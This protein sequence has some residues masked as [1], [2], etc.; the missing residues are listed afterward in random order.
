MQKLL[1]TI[2]GLILLPVA[3]SAQRGSN[4]NY[5]KI[6]GVVLEA[7]G[8]EQPINFAT[9]QLLPQGTYVSTDANGN[10][11]FAKVH[12]GKV[13]IKVQF[14]GMQDIDT[15]VNVIAAKDYYFEFKMKEANFRLEEIVVSAQR[16]QAG[17]STA[18]NINRQAMDHLQ[19]STIKDVM[20]LLPGVSIENPNLNEANTISL[21]T[22]AKDARTNMSSLGTAIIMD[23]SPLSNNANLQKLSSTANGNTK[24][25]MYLGDISAGVDIRKVSLDNVESVE[26]IRGIPSAEYGDLTSGAVIINSK[27]G[28]EPL[29]VRFK[30]NPQL[31]E[32]SASKGFNVGK[33]GGAFHISG[34]YAHKHKT[35][36]YIANTGKETRL[37]RMAV[38]ADTI[39]NYD[40]LHYISHLYYI[41][42][43]AFFQHYVANLLS[44]YLIIRVGVCQQ[45][46]RVAYGMNRMVQYCKS[47]K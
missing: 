41:V 22:A 35:G 13:Q 38:N 16:S 21:R 45:V 43:A 10:F 26:V 27:A 2:F 46:R 14:V 32:V 18:S 5:A 11:S 42:Y 7:S 23:G 36:R 25:A 37:F 12:P 47:A 20:Q 4:S 39:H 15:T 28:K 8:G 1:L 44:V 29:S 31:Y 34:N 40:T 6:E 30:T 9:V 24:D 17:S 3:M 19:A 33:K